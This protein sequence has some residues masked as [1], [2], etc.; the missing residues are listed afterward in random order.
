M[1]EIQIIGHFAVPAGED[2]KLLPCRSI[3]LK[4]VKKYLDSIY[5]VSFKNMKINH[6]LTETED[7]LAIKKVDIL[8]MNEYKKFI[9][10]FKASKY[11]HLLNP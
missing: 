9:D 5:N 1:N 2:F 11:G 10:E 6:E 4:D 8:N 7:Y 3:E